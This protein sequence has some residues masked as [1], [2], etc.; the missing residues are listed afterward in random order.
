VAPFAQLRRL[1]SKLEFIRAVEAA[2]LL[3]PRTERVTDLAALMQ[4]L[5]DDVVI[6]P[7]YSRFATEALVRPTREQAARVDVS[8]ERPWVM[9]ELVRGRPVCSYAVAHEGRLTAYAAYGVEY[10]AGL[11]SS[12]RFQSDDDPAVFDWVSRF[13]AAERFTG[14]IAFD[15][16]VRD[17][18]AMPLECNPRATSGVHLFAGQPALAQS[19]LSAA[20]PLLRPRS[21]EATM[22]AVPMLL[23]G[24]PRALRE[25]RLG[26]FVRDF[27]TSRD[28]VF[29]RDDPGP[30]LG[31]AAALA[32]LVLMA[33]RHGRGL[34]AASTADIEYNGE[35]VCAFS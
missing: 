4:K 34:L 24:L 8:P 5:S 22:V 6:K 9:Q 13:V 32:E 19:F 31:Q 17:G 7:E 3:A 1:H 28:V 12:I 29:R 14:Q 25:G 35:D 21:E 2:G 27:R 30:A 15:F 20:A 33:G 10:T 16:I 23:Y 11:A 26:R 18:I